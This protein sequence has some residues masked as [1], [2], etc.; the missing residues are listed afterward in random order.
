MEQQCNSDWEKAKADND[1]VQLFKLLCDSH[2][3][4]GK[5]ASLV[6]LREIRLKHDTFSWF[7]PEDLQHFKLR[8]VKLIIKEMTRVGIGAE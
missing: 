5:Q 3:F 6:E 1:I 7:S 8:W 4:Y 2:S